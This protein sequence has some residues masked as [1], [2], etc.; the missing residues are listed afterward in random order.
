[1]FYYFLDFFKLKSIISLCLHYKK[2]QTIKI[3]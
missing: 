2:F 1:M 3:E